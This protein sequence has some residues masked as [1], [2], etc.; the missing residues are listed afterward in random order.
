MV[1]DEQVVVVVRPQFA[2]SDVPGFVVA[3]IRELGLGAHGVSRDEALRNL[4]LMYVNAVRTRR[5]YGK[6][7]EW[8]NHSGLKWCFRPEYSGTQPVINAADFAAELAADRLSTGSTTRFIGET[9]ERGWSSLA[10]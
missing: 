4:S 5:K 9:E 6:L 2:T 10:A 1:R 3:E 8:L 7:E